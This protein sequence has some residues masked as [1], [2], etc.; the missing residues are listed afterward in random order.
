MGHRLV[1]ETMYI[2]SHS[3]L[4]HKFEADNLYVT[5]GPSTSSR[6]LEILKSSIA[7]NMNTLYYYISTSPYVFDSYSLKCELSLAKQ[8]QAN[9]QPF[10]CERS[11]VFVLLANDFPS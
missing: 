10:A 5:L 3:V 2:Y 7:L 11:F 4:K 6:V 9:Q 1:V 8:K